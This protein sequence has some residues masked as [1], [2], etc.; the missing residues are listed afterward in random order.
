MVWLTV[1]MFVVGLGTAIIFYRQF[2]Q[3]KG[4]A[5]ILNDQAK[6]AAADSIEAGK[7]VEQQLH[8]AA[9]QVQA[10]QNSVKAIQ[11]QMRQDQRAVSEQLVR[12]G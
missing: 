4:Q 5:S 3:M 12:S 1:L 10:A 9:Q 7:R 6:Q 8:L 11:Q 2:G